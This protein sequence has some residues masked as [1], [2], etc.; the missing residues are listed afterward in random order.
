MTE[1][2]YKM[3]VDFVEGKDRTIIRKPEE[4]PLLLSCKSGFHKIR[5]RE[6]SK[7]SAVDIPY[8]ERCNKVPYDN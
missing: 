2:K 5:Y 1:E 3:G 8:C 7:G 6:A 4:K